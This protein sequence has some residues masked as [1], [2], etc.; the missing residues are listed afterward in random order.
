[1]KLSKLVKRIFSTILIFVILF[2]GAAISIPYFFKEEI[3]V[4][5]K[6][7]ANNTLNAKINFADVDL[8]L[9]RS[10][11]DFSFKMD[12]LIVTGINDFEGI[13]L[14]KAKNIDF[15]LDLISVIKSDRPVVIKMITFDQPEV[16]ILV[17]DTGKANYDIVKLSEPSNEPPAEYD[18]LIQLKKYAINDGNFT[19][20][21]RANNMFLELKN[22]NHQGNGDFTQ[23]VFDLTTK[24]NIEQLSAISGGVRYLKKV[25][26]SLDAIFNINLNKNTYTL[27]NNSLQINAMKLLADGYLQLQ[28]NE[29]IEINLTFDAPKNDFKNLL[30]LIPSAYTSDFK[31]VKADG[32]ITFNGYLKGIYNARKELF[33]SF[34]INLDVNQG[35]FQY[36]DLPSGFNNIF[37]NINIENHS[38]NFDK[39]KIDIPDFKFALGGKPFEGRFKLTTP[40]S[41][42]N[43]DTKIKGTIDLAEISKAFP[44]E[45]VTELSGIINADFT[46]Q[47]QLSILDKGQYGDANISGNSSFKNLIYNAQ[48]IPKVFIRDAQVTL[49]P[50]N[51][52]ISNFTGKLGKSDLQISGQLDNILAYFSPKKTLTGNIKLRSTY[53]NVDEWMIEM[54]KETPPPISSESE[55]EIEIFNRFKFIVDAKIGK[56][57]YDVYQLDNSSAKGIFTSNEL[58]INNFKTILGESDISGKGNFINVFNYIFKNE[59]LGGEFVMRSNLFDLN[60]FMEEPEAPKSKKIANEVEEYTPIIIP[61]N[62]NIN[63][64]ANIK[65]LTYTN[66]NLKDFSGNLAIKDSKIQMSN[67]NGRTLGGKIEANGYYD[68]SNPGKPKYKL[69][70]DVKSFDFNSSFK[71][72]N[73]VKALAP[74]AKYIQGN[75][76]TKMSLEG[77]LGEDLMPDLN[78]LTAEGFLQTV[79]GVIQD[80]T[81]LK[82]IGEA[83]NIKKLTNHKIDLKGTKNWFEIEDGNVLIKEFPLKYQGIDMMIGGSHG[84]TQDIDYDIKAKIP[85]KLI[86]QN[87][88]GNTASNG[89][90]K[91]KNQASKLG[92]NIKEKEFVNLKI[93]LTGS[94]TNPKVQFSLVGSG[95]KTVQGAITEKVEEVKDKVKTDV[96]EIIEKK[97]EDLSKVVAERK[98]KLEREAN[99][100]IQKLTSAA[101]KSAEKIRLEGKN[102]AGK[103][104]KEGYKQ[105]DLIVKEAGS[106]PIK[107]RLAKAGANKIKKETDKKSQQLEDKANQNADKVIKEADEKAAEISLEYQK[108]IDA[109]TIDNIKK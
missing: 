109:V 78:T 1:M 29:N 94:M 55:Q 21:D 20:D 67:L 84:I 7:E 58:I 66:I 97:K 68:T 87:T 108:K 92:L 8:S 81:P 49:S 24:T 34:K 11:P 46:A 32:K 70:Y 83:L 19:Y 79:N 36:P 60:P 25:N 102:A 56:I 75:Y 98:A 40:I 39:I 101:I 105:A 82:K 28:E 38:S 77:V 6:E 53:L 18:F 106:N 35:S 86:N 3:L 2:L 95:G 45:G 88:V 73:T 59:T 23:D 61:D 33:P 62:I 17:L 13:N 41:D 107:K 43:I 100:R 12:Q 103:V 85:M 89:I 42:P 71:Q 9:L 47:T 30:S 99:D 69:T 54:E 44:L 16:N 80:F 90:K 57:D 15:T 22:L 93:K 5:I 4:K 48:G 51:I 76:S 91:L 31:D 10:F 72:I 14:V 96:N 64:N 52:E 37:A 74:I 26:T 65:K 63:I 104:K 50:Q 27:K